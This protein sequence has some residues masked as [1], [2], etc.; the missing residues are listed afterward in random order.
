VIFASM[1]RS[2]ADLLRFASISLGGAATGAFAGMLMASLRDFDFIPFSRW[3]MPIALAALMA[4]LLQF[5]L[6]DTL[7]L[8]EKRKEGSL[9]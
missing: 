4:V 5:T 9:G 3:W 1:R 6:A 2:K 7:K 8:A